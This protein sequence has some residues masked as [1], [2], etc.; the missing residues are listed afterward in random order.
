MPPEHN[1]VSHVSC[2]WSE[3]H[4]AIAL[5]KLSL[6]RSLL[7]L[8]IFFSEIKASTTTQRFLRAT[9]NYQGIN[10]TDGRSCDCV[11]RS[12]RRSQHG[13]ADMAW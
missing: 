1:T 4:A 9:F 3:E 13:D 6:C 10:N 7:D 12:W 5:R 11:K 8:V 2:I